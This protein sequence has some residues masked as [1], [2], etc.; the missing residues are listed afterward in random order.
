MAGRRDTLDGRQLRLWTVRATDAVSDDA[1]G[2]VIA[3]D[4]ASIHVTCGCG[5]LEI[6]SLQPAGKRRMP[7]RDFLNA[8]DIGGAVLGV[9]DDGG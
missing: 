7:A 6:L 9:A 3:T 5:V 4:E 1:P 8:H 2:T